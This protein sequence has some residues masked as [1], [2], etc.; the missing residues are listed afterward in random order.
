MKEKRFASKVNHPTQNLMTSNTPPPPVL[1][2]EREQFV[3]EEVGDSSS[4]LKIL[5]SIVAS[6]IAGVALIVLAI[7]LS[8][9]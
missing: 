5:V 4:K 6:T 9:C 7:R 2:H 8:Q 1:V 3:V